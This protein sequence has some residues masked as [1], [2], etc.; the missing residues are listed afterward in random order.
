MGG[1]A[2]SRVGA[3]RG[4]GVLMLDTASF[5]DHIYAHVNKAN[6]MLGFIRRTISW[7]KI[8]L[9]TLRSPFY[10]TL[11]RSHVENASEI[12]SPKSVTMLKRTERV[13]R[14]ATWLMLPN[15]SYNERL[16]R[17]S[18]LPSQPAEHT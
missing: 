7:S 14:R 2:L 17:L 11:V 15:F 16:K 4:L 13:Q 3:Q 9:P 1:K 5:S 10:A 18:L 8:V 6:K 12:W